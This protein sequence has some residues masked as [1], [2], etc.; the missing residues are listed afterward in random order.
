MRTV[1]TNVTITPDG[2]LIGQV[3]PD[4]PPG[5]HRALVVI[6]EESKEHGG[7]DP[8]E[9]S[10]YPFGLV[11]DTMTFRREDIYDESGR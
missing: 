9:F 1:E 3:P 11:S 6:D 2:H 5:E 7:N 8:L 4:V 10:P